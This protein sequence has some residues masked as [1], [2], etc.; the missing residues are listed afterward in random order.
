[1]VQM[2]A[3]SWTLRRL[4]EFIDSTAGCRALS[5]PGSVIPKS[6][7]NYANLVLLEENSMPC[8]FPRSLSKQH[9]IFTL[10]PLA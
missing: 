10:V 5:A 2:A 1:M 6:L 8:P 7:D 4:S 3:S 9:S